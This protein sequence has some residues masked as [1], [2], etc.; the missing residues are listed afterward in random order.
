MSHDGRDCFPKNPAVPGRWETVVA[1]GGDKA[2]EASV[3]P[4]RGREPTGEAAAWDVCCAFAGGFRGARVR[5]RPH[6]GEACR[7]GA[8][9]V[10]ARA[11]AVRAHAPADAPLHHRR[12][13]R[14]GE[15]PQQGPR[16]RPQRACAHRGAGLLA[17]LSRECR[18]GGARESP[19]GCLASQLLTQM[20][21]TF[22]FV[23]L[24]LRKQ[25]RVINFVPLFIKR[26]LF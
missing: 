22:C 13:G 15:A 18:E 5:G 16:P 7:E 11:A 8:G 12:G 23:D 9:G 10:P 26:K 6:L 1:G 24:I 3:T 2:G 21:S 25:H 4:C 14:R 20:K 17:S 19:G